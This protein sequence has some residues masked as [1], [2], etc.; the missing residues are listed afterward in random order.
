MRTLTVLATLITLG[1]PAFADT[2]ATTHIDAPTEAAK[3]DKMPTF[4]CGHPAGC[5]NR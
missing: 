1:A 3:S 4:P 2:Y 5:T